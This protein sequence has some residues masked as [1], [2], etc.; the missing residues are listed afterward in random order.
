MNETNIN[1]NMI[2]KGSKLSKKSVDYT[3]I[4][5]N[6]NIQQM[7]CRFLKK[8]SLIFFNILKTFVRFTD[9]I[10]NVLTKN[11]LLN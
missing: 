5:S 9:E 7:K 6:K 1:Y 3:C 2:Q 10:L 4:E 11:T 8:I